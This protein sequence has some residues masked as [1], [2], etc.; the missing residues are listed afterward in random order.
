MQII[1]H[2]MCSIDDKSIRCIAGVGDASL[3]LG[4]V[5]PNTAMHRCLCRCIA[6]VGDISSRR[7]DPQRCI[8]RRRRA[9][10]GWRNRLERTFLAADLDRP[11]CHRRQQRRGFG[12]HERTL[13]PPGARRLD[14][15]ARAGRARAPTGWHDPGSGSRT[16]SGRLYV[17]R[18]LLEPHLPPV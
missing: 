12:V 9:P 16:M 7:V 4:D 14:T 13:S 1:T 6:G 10:R 18:F 5:S 3:C 11:G 15:R 2:C 17:G 8:A